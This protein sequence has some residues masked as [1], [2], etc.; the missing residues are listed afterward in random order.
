M[1]DTKRAFALLVK[2]RCVSEKA[3]A[4]ERGSTNSS[5]M[6]LYHQCVT[7]DVPEVLL[8]QPLLARQP[9]EPSLLQWQMLSQERSSLALLLP[10]WCPAIVG[11]AVYGA[12]HVMQAPR[13]IDLFDSSKNNKNKAISSGPSGHAPETLT[14]KQ[15]AA[16]LTTAQPTARS[17]QNMTPKSRQNYIHFAVVCPSHEDMLPVS[18]MLLFLTSHDG[19]CIT[20][21][22]GAVAVHQC[23]RLSGQACRADM[24]ANR[25]LSRS[26]ICLDARSSTLLRPCN[27]AALGQRWSIRASNRSFGRLRSSSSSSSGGG[28]GRD[29][30]AL[31]M[32][33]NR[34]FDMVTGGAVLM[35]RNC[36]SLAGQ[37]RLEPP[38]PKHV[39]LAVHPG[40]LA[41]GAAALAAILCAVLVA[42]WCCWCFRL[43]PPQE[44]VVKQPEASVNEE[45]IAKQVKVSD[46]LDPKLDAAFFFD[47]RSELVP[48]AGALPSL[49]C[50]LDVVSICGFYFPGYQERWDRLCGCSFLS[51]Y[52]DREGGS[53][54]LEVRGITRT[55]KNAEAAFQAL[56]FWHRS[57]DFECLSGEEAV[58]LQMELRGAEDYSFSGIG[59]SWDAM[60]TVLEVKF[61]KD[62][63]MGDALLTTGDSFILEHSG[64]RVSGG[65]VWEN[66]DVCC[67]NWLGIQLMLIRDRLASTD[68]WTHYL[69]DVI[70]LGVG[71]PHDDRPDGKW[72]EVVRSA[73]MMLDKQVVCGGVELE[74]SYSYSATDL[75]RIVGNWYGAD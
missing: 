16:F 53:V 2:P 63:I 27:R 44:N 68:R 56:K 43:Q 39:H 6:A 5:T 46:P 9:G 37:W 29:C 65:D 64:Q 11:L 62:S 13:N 71:R 4:N 74:E 34:S 55:F 18:Q 26:G 23:N 21:A 31:S 10:L 38:S 58:T 35:L 33:T 73:S 20:V 7:E 8:P 25:S 22:R 57:E 1:Y 47:P 54:Q 48:E 60:F 12:T 32:H 50:E 17:R 52:Y 61:K 75:Q 66:S 59:S 70:D 49:D 69:E 28:K 72:Q 36:T 45:V 41:I 67:E 30:L 42:A 24:T 3:S 40:L 51:T 19:V 15:I 14:A